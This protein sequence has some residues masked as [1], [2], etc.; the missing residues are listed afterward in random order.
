MKICFQVD[1]CLGLIQVPYCHFWKFNWLKTLPSLTV[2][3]H[4]RTAMSG[5][6]INI[7]STSGIR[8]APCYDFYT[9]KNIS[10]SF[11]NNIYFASWTVFCSYLF[12]A[13]FWHLYNHLFREGNSSF[14]NSLTL[15]SLA[16]TGSKFALEGI[17]DSL[18]YSLAPFNI[19]IT[20]INPGPVR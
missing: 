9:G 14:S 16:C 2:L 17:T 1:I 18:R 15:W 8:G 3:P 19:P 10:L 7:S 5:Y 13:T 11:L 4:M 12:L 6:V 20:N